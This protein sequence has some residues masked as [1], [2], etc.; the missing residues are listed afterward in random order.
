MT[1]Q[2]WHSI[3]AV[4]TDPFAKQQPAASKAAEIARR[5]SGRLTLLNTFMIPQP[6][7]DVAMGDYKQIIVS[8]IR[9]RKRRLEQLAA[10][11][12]CPGMTIK[13]VVEWDYP[14]HE[15]IVRHVLRSKPDLLV[16][17]SH[18]HGRFARWLLSNTDWELMRH[19]PCA[20]WFVR[21][22]RIATRPKVLV[23]VDPCHAREKPARLDDRLL[24]AAA[25]LAQEVDGVV[26]MAHVREVTESTPPERKARTAIDLAIDK[27]AAR[28]EIPAARC[29][30]IDGM[31]H[32]ALPA[33][34]R[35]RG[36][37]VLV[38]GI[39][40][41]SVAERPVIGNTAEKVIDHVGCDVLVV[42][43]AG[44]KT[45]VTRVR[46]KLQLP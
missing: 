20:L 43:P 7:A 21:D 9:G 30:I 16:S 41:R 32:K 44:F 45:H 17:E 25:M 11:L 33:I 6:V 39:V 31:P 12:R 38:M 26:E 18:R 22:A 24:Q 37:E 36:A 3:V 8:A 13:C 15:A 29:H 28:H 46:P 40:S 14:A 19:C 23:A 35:R 1:V 2:Q 10:K 27:L 34:A 5:C 4:V 42:K